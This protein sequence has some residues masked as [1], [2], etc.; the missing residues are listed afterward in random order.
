MVDKLVVIGW[1][2]ATWDYIDPLI[3]QGALPNIERLLSRGARF[4]LRS[5]I[6][7]YTNIAW[8]ALVTGC[9]PARTGVFDAVRFQ[10]GSYSPLAAGS[11]RTEPIWRW[12]NQFGKRA[13]V[14]N[15]PTTYPAIPLDGYLVT[16]FDSPRNAPDIEYPRG[17]IAS[18]K[19]HH[20]FYSVLSQETALMDSQNPH[21]LR[22]DLEDFTARWEEITRQQGTHLAWLWKNDP[23]DLLFSVFSGTDSINHR[24]RNFDHITRVYRAADDALGY[25]LDLVDENTLFGI[26]SDH[27]STAAKR[28]ISLNRILHEQNWLQFRK[29]L[30][31]KHIQR[32]PGLAGKSLANVWRQ[33][34]RLLQHTASATLIWLDPRLVVAHENIDW[35]HT[36]IFARSSMGPLYVNLQGRFPEGNVI[37]SEYDSLLSE[38]SSMILAM[39][40]PDGKPL[41]R[42]IYFGREIHQSTSENDLIPDLILEPFDWSDHMITGFPTDP[43]V[44]LIPNEGEYGTHTP[45]GIFLLTGPGI[46]TGQFGV[47]NIQDVVPTLL[48]AWGLPLPSTAD[49]VV[50]ADVFSHP[51]EITY[52]SS[53]QTP[54][55][56][57][58]NGDSDEVLERLRA[59][60]YLE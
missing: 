14:L 38:A 12:V 21:Q 7:P 27:G 29:T 3:K 56:P 37:P 9:T 18:W 1:D 50:L 36:K 43:L 8:P 31:E 16:G 33:L 15:V 2:G 39:R 45:D 4:T 58:A 52:A 54:P 11:G 5:T 59:L 34:P 13:G 35:P 23:V 40:G 60:G 17:L 57:H 24:T 20:Q 32:L 6:P 28:Y 47:A 55:L 19:Q 51:L 26:V 48:A 41:F 30:S 42:H 25:L 53:E 22:S 44:R 49:G 46:Q 10:P